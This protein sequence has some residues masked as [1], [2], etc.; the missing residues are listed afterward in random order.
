V[1]AASSATVT[2]A[3]DAAGGDAASTQQAPPS[4]PPGGSGPPGRG[5][6]LTRG[7][8]ELGVHAAV[9]GTVVLVVNGIRYFWQT[10][11]RRRGGVRAPIF[12]R[13]T[14]DQ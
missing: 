6:S 3:T 7:L 14:A 4:Q 9:M 2:S 10:I 5:G 11:Q 1:Q 12:H 13:A 8:P